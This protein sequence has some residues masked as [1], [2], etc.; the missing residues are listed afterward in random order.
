MRLVTIVTGIVVNPE[1]VSSVVVNHEFDS[2]T[3]TMHNGEKFHLP[4][5]Y[6]RSVWKTGDRIV[7]ALEG[8]GVQ[9]A[10]DDKS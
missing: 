8:G 10:S 3:V 7:E 4:C 6:G 2:V 5:D 9:G 1:E